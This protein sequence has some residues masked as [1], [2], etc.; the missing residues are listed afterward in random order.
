MLEC[1]GGEEGWNYLA[2]RNVFKI[3]V[4][5]PALIMEGVRTCSH[6]GMRETQKV[7]TSIDVKVA[8]IGAPSGRRTLF[9]EDHRGN[10]SMH[11]LNVARANLVDKMQK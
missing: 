5:V 7:T 6:R 8:M 1:P 3:S 4:S 10:A 2:K 11:W 9:L